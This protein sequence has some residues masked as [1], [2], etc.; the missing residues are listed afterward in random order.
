MTSP[1]ILI[2]DDDP[3]I[4]ALLAEVVRRAG[5]TPVVAASGVEGYAVL[6]SARTAISVVLLDLSMAEMDGVRFREMQLEDPDLAQVPVIILTGQMLTDAELALMRPA[7]V[8]TKPVPIAEIRAALHRVLGP[9]PRS[10]P[11]PPATAGGLSRA[12]RE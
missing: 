8:L 11:P 12:P 6:A 2:V 1:R 7:A 9:S 3:A 4:R 10:T 5:S